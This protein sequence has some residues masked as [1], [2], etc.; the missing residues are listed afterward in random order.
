MG[1]EAGHLATYHLCVVTIAS[2]PGI[3]LMREQLRLMRGELR[4]TQHLCRLLADRHR[5]VAHAA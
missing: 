4:H 3:V 1:Q 5:V 2:Q